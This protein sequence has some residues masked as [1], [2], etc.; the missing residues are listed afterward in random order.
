MTRAISFVLLAAALVSGA[1]RAAEQ[2][3]ALD[4]DKR[5]TRLTAPVEDPHD[6]RDAIGEVHAER[7]KALWSNDDYGAG[8]E[9]ASDESVILR[10]RAASTAAFNEPADWILERYR[11]ALEE[12]HARGIAEREHFRELFDIYLAASDYE[13]AERLVRR[14]PD[15]EFPAIPQRIPPGPAPSEDARRLWRIADDP[16][17]LEG[18]YLEPGAPRLLIVSSPSCGYCRL[19]ARALPDDGVLGPLMHEYAIWLVERSPANSYRRML[20]LN[21][22]FPEAPHYYVDDPAD[23][24]V[25]DFSS[26]PIFHF[27]DGA[28]IRETLAGWRGGSEAMWAIARGFESIGLLDGESLPEGAF[29]YADAG[30]ARCPT[31]DGALQLIAERAPITTREE[32]DAHLAE[33]RAGGESPLL[34]LSPEARKRLLASIRFGS[35]GVASI[36]IDD[37]QAQLESREIREVASLFGLQHAFAGTLFPAELLGP[38]DRNLKDMRDC[39]GRY[40][41]SETSP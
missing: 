30:S 22:E 7:F 17:R 2:P 9:A 23:W 8:L 33:M 5:F 25:P 3:S 11:A 34:A 24:P 40:A 41:A 29:A 6:G 37:L 21:R 16:L 31:R 35:R 18:F 19:A 36:R 13:R 1:G 20:A 15:I 39:T 27:F 32:L 26:T 4:D 28:G 10:L 12:A 38:D 14:F